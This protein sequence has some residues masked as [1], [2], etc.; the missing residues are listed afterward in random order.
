MKK[1]IAIL[2]FC[3][4]LYMNAQTNYDRGY[5]RGWKE[6]YCQNYDGVSCLPPNPPMTPMSRINENYNSYKDGYNRGFTDGLAAYSGENSRSN[7]QGRT[8]KTSDL[9]V[10]NDFYRAPWQEINN[11]LREKQAIHDRNIESL[12]IARD[13]IFE[14]IMNDNSLDNDDKK[15]M[16][17]YVNDRCINSLKGDDFA[18]SSSIIFVDKF[19]NC[20]WGVI[21]EEKERIELEHQ[22]KVEY[23]KRKEKQRLERER[24][25]R[26][27]IEKE[28]LKEEKIKE[29][30]NKNFGKTYKGEIKLYE[31]TPL[32]EQPDMSSKEICRIS[33]GK[34]LVLEKV[35]NGK[36]YKVRA[37][38]KIG[39][40]FTGFIK[41]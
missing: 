14:K 26:E 16:I 8:F 4:T 11:V 36:Y 6:G 38:G 9:E 12:I 22:I 1:I 21:K 2:V 15:S 18:I 19:N 28:R 24:I 27:R 3:Q 41:Q 34:V 25:E 7:R 29:E 37:N 32:Y 39:Y 33:E 23:Q 20:A 31:Y 17:N 40:I 30:Y 13:K 35:S 10:F 5:Q